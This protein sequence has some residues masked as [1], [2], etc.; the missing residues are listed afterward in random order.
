MKNLTFE[1]KDEIR[2]MIA[3]YFFALFWFIELIAAIFNYMIIVGV[4]TWYFTSTNDRGGSFSLFR[5]LWW[6]FRYNLGS[7]AFGSFLCALLWVIRIIFEYVTKKLENANQ[8]QG[9]VKCI[10]CACRCCLDCLH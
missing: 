2:W 3:V 6:A 7:L 9:I 4:S 5:G 10:T 1:G 8:N